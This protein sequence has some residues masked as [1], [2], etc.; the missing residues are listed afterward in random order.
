MAKWS[1]V[2]R[3]TK[4]SAGFIPTE[5]GVY[6]FLGE[7]NGN[8]YPLIYVGHTDNLRDRY[9]NDTKGANRYVTEHAVNYRFLLEAELAERESI[10]NELIQERNPVGNAF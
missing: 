10:A 8:L 6:V 4:E 9:L 5:S 7:L 3:F 1:K 2:L